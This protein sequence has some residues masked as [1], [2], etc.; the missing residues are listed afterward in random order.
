ML[1]LVDK[2][3]LNGIESSG[4]QNP[5]HLL[6][7]VWKSAQVSMKDQLQLI[8]AGE[9]KKSRNYDYQVKALRCP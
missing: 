4:A 5:H 3:S 9:Q 7:Y 2:P 6:L 1:S 8:H